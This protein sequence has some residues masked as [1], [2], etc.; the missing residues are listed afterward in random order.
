MTDWSFVMTDRSVSSVSLPAME[1]FDTSNGPLAYDQ[2]GVGNPIFFMHSGGHDHHDFDELRELLPPRFRSIAPDWPGHGSSPPSPEPASAMRFADLAEQI[3]ATLAP[4]GALVV[5]S[6]VGGFAAARLAIRRP[7]LVR[8]LVLLDSGGFLGRPLQVRLFCGLMARPGFLR[9]IYPSFSARYMRARTDADRR[10][11]EV[12]IATTRRDAGLK[13]VSE[14]WRSFAS[15][16]HDL[17]AEAPRIAAPTL[18]VWG[19][20]DPVIPLRVGKWLAKEIPG[21]RLAVFDSGHLPHTT[22]PAGV[23][24]ELIPFADAAFGRRERVTAA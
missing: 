14:L 22:D 4:E 16:E 23:A 12:S 1:T 24:A 5:G 18:V 10:A 11:R 17:R 2:R 15:P 21:A 3:V 9:R 7:E 13:T 19:R 8:G 20:R 6:S